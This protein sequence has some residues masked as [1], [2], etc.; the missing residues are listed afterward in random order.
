MK[1]F[2]LIEIHVMNFSWKLTDECNEKCTQRAHNPKPRFFGFLIAS[3]FRHTHHAYIIICTIRY[4]NRSSAIN[5][6]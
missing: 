1:S 3:L 2:D 6:L 5:T 4:I